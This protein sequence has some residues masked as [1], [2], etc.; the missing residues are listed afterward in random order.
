MGKRSGV[1]AMKG[2][3]QGLHDAID[4][5]CLARQPERLKE[6]TH[7]LVSRGVEGRLASVV[8]GWGSEAHAG[9][10]RCSKTCAR[11]MR[12]PWKLARCLRSPDRVDRRQ[13]RSQPSTLLAAVCGSQDSSRWGQGAS[14]GTP[15]GRP[16]RSL[17][18]SGGPR[19]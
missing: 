8:G 15:R 3:S 19:L 5:L 4:L 7:R 11:C 14:R 1:G 10:C 6:D 13:S 18:W 12:N 2:V 17:S 9:D 16:Y